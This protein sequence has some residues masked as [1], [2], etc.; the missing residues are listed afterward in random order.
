MK[1]TFLAIGITALL[2]MLF[3]PH[4]RGLTYLESYTP[5][6]FPRMSSRWFPIFVVDVDPY[7]YR[8]NVNPVLLGNFGGQTAFLAVLAAVLANLRKARGEKREQ[9]NKSRSFLLN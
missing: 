4:E 7:A 3:A 6:W 1:R 9:T 5:E 8:R 2:S